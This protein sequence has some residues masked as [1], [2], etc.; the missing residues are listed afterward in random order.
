MVNIAMFV[1]FLLTTIAVVLICFY[2]FPALVA[3]GAVPLYGERLSRSA[4]PRWPSRA[5]AWLLVV[6]APA[7]SGRRPW[8]VDPLG[9][10][11]A[12]VAALCQAS[13]FLISGRGLQP[14]PSPQSRPRHRVAMVL[15]VSVP[16]TLVGRC[17]AASSGAA[18][19]QPEAWIWILA[20]GI[21]GAAIPTTS[22]LAGIGIIGPS[23]AAILMTI[24]PLVGVTIA[25]LLPGRTAELHPDR[26]RRGRPGRG[27]SSRSRRAAGRRRA[28][29][30]PAGLA[31][32]V[33]RWLQR[34]RPRLYSRPTHHRSPRDLR[35]TRRHARSAI[36]QQRYVL[37]VRKAVF[38]AAGWGTRFLPAT[39]AQPKEML[40][41]VD[42]PVIQYGI[43]EA[44]AAGIE[45]VIIVTSSQKRAD[46]G[47]L[48]PQLRARAAARG[49]GRHRDAA[50]SP[51]D[52]RHGPDQ[53]RAPEGAA[54]AWATR[55]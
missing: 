33:S 37:R 43:E 36:E 48:R 4:P 30:R 12:F 15:A 6:L 19:Q 42:K 49:Q 14:M 8:C 32:V 16:L 39:K 29:V 5:P 55:C 17:R 1:A 11:L 23:R 25:A 45:Q 34:I 10:G 40:P 50:A 20:G 41:L 53:L 47:P 52:R 44:V 3:L 27:R 22:F 26:G 46:R 18:F 38:P 35:L 21:T 9:V 54:R 7:R 31:S 13:F 28:G 51:P 2:T 24:E